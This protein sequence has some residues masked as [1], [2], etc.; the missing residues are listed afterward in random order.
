M[1]SQRIFL[2][3]VLAMGFLLSENPQ[4]N[5]FPGGYLG[6]GVQI[7]KTKDGPKFMDLQISAGIVALGPYKQDLPFFLFLGASSG[8]RN[9]AGNVAKYFDLNAGLWSM[10]S[11]G[12]G[13]GWINDGSNKKI[14][15]KKYWGG[16]GFLPLI[17]CRDIHYVNE[18]KNI[19]TGVMGVLPFPMFGNNFYP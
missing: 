17:L 4:E 16:P 2:A 11:L 10:L 19:Q 18:K 12:I 15:R 1:R 14:P 3:Q 8:R 13:K 9:A 5:S 7:G 6:L